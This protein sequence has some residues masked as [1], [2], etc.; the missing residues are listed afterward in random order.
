[1]DFL[2]SRIKEDYKVNK[3][4]IEKIFD[5]FN[6]LF[7]YTNLSEKIFHLPFIQFFKSLVNDNST[8]ASNNKFSKGNC[9][10]DPVDSGNFCQNK[11]RGEEDNITTKNR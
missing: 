7:I 11:D 8:D 2:Q 4:T 6:S 3:E 1:M 5:F 9:C 10:P